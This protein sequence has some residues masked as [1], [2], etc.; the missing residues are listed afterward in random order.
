M[1]KEDLGLIERDRQ[2]RET[3]RGGGQELIRDT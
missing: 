1:W 2:R 3:E